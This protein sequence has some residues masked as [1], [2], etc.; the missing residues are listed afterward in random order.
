MVIKMKISIIFGMFTI[1]IYG[2]NDLVSCDSLI[3][4]VDRGVIYVEKMPTPIGGLD[5]LQSRLI[6]PKRAKEGNI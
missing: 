3:F 6:Y 5:S 2:Q 1:A 4:E